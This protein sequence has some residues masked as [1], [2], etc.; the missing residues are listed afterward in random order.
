MNAIAS[1]LPPLAVRAQVPRRADRESLLEGGADVLEGGLRSF[2][3]LPSFIY[4]AVTGSAA[5]KQI[6]FDALSRLPLK[7]ISA[8]QTIKMVPTLGT[9]DAHGGITLGVTRVGTGDM[10]LSRWRN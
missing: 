6:I 8:I 9:P 5:E 3:A 4:P 1:T 10:Q 7:D 2:Q